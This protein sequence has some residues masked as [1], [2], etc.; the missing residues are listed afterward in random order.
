MSSSFLPKLVNDPFADSA[1]FVPFFFQKR[2]F[3]LDLGEIYSVSSRDLL[4]TSHVFVTHTHMDHFAGFDRLIRVFLGRDKNLFIY[5]PKG[6]LK[7]VEGKLAGY[8]W[9]LAKNYKTC[10]TLYATEVCSKRLITKKFAF[11]N[12]FAPTSDDTINSFDGILLKEPELTVYAKILDHIIPCL[13]FSIKERFHINIIKDNLEKLELGTGPWLT[14]FKQALFNNAE[15]D[16]KIIAS[17]KNNEKIEFSL[18]DLAGRIAQITE[19]QKIT[20]IS[21]VIC[22]K[23][24]VEKIVELAKDSDH[25]F[26]EAVFLEKDKDMAKKKYHLTARQAGGIAGMAGVKQFT[27][28]HFSPRYHEKEHLLYMEAKDAYDKG[29]NPLA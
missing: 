14:T 11:N 28:F 4:K 20:Y 17:S 1:L 10:F 2:A 29:V 21:D 15:P 25:L 6:F 24:N 26:I 12:S 23:S 27:I 16:S 9:N 3:F 8:S 22:S 18:K 7:N 19:G 13:G 5:G